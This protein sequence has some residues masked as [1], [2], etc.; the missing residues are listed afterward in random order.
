MPYIK[1]DDRERLQTDVVPRNGGELNY[2][3][4]MLM[5]NYIKEHGVSYETCKDID[6]VLGNISKEFYRRKVAPYE[7]KKALENGDIELYDTGKK[8]K[9]TTF[10]VMQSE[11]GQEGGGI[12]FSGSHQECVNFCVSQGMPRL[13]EDI[14]GNEENMLEISAI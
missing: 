1:Q 2:A 9:N 4:H 12:L 6:G 13:S 8:D 7:D 14:Y 11:R 5:T 3:I 10:V